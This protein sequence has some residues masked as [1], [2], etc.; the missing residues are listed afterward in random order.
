[1]NP[2]NREFR[3]EHNQ[4]TAEYRFPEFNESSQSLKTALD[5]Y[6]NH[7]PYGEW[8]KASFSA[9]LQGFQASHYSG[10]DGLHNTA[11]HTDIASPYATDP[12]WSLLKK[13]IGKEELQGLEKEGLSSWHN[14]LT[15][16][17]PDIIL[18]SASKDWEKEKL[19]FD[20]ISSWKQL[21]IDCKVPINHAKIII[22]DKTC[23]I[24]AQTQGRKP[25]LN[26]NRD[27]KLSIG[28]LFK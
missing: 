18:F 11:I 2:S 4:Y 25:F 5:S 1:L 7:K 21:Q 8:F 3:N 10:L 26:A 16:L 6:F 13:A 24:I 23:D 27:Q 17:E 14:L 19:N 22:N 20:F 28:K 9:I 12:T 15:T